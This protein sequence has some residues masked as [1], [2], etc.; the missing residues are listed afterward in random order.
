MMEEVVSAVLAN[1]DGDILTLKRASHKK[2]YPGVWDTVAG[3]KEPNEG[4]EECL[5][6]EV[7]EEL[8]IED[9][10]VLRQSRKTKYKDNGREWLATIFLCKLKNDIIVLNEEHSEYR[11]M[12][13]SRIREENCSQP[14]LK[15]LKIIF[16]I[17][18]DNPEKNYSA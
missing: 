1:D 3:K 15:D 4:D 14:F 11:W 12:P 8:G 10:D 18:D 9:F 6:R 7:M 2:H 16:G 5:R 17:I 13:L